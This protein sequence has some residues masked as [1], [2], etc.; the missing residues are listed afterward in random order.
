A[1]SSYGLDGPWGAVTVSFGGFPSSYTTDQAQWQFLDLLPA[2]TWDSYI[3]DVRACSKTDDSRCGA[4]GLWDRRNSSQCANSGVYMQGSVYAQ[5]MS[6][7]GGISG[8][9]GATCYNSSTVIVEEMSVRYPDGTNSTAIEIGYL[10]LGAKSST[11]SFALSDKPDD[12]I[13]TYNL[14]GFFYDNEITSSNSFSL[15]Y[16]A[17][18]LGFKGSLI[19]G[20]YDKGRAIGSA[21]TFGM[22]PPLL[23]DIV[24]GV[25]DGGSPF[26][27]TSKSGLLFDET[28]KSAQV[29]AFPDPITPYINL[30]RQTC[31]AIADLLPVSFD[32][33][34]GFYLWDVN[35][36]SFTTIISSPA[37]LGFVFPPAPGST[38]DVTIKVPLFLLNLTLD[39]QLVGGSDSVPYFPC[40]PFSMVGDATDSAWPTQGTYYLGRAFLQA[41]YYGRN[42][43]AGVSWLAQTPGPGSGDGLG[44]L[45][46]D[47]I[48]SDTSI[49]TFDDNGQLN[50]S[51]AGHWTPI[52]KTTTPTPVNTHSSTPTMT[53]SNNNTGL[54]TG[55]QAGIGV[56]VG[57][58]VLLALGLLF[59]FR[60]R[61]NAR[62][63]LLSGDA[64]VHDTPAW[65]ADDSN[66]RQKEKRQYV[67]EV[68]ASD[69]PHNETSKDYHE[70][71]NNIPELSSHEAPQELAGSSDRTT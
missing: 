34:S 54:S 13:N 37:Y 62:K 7:G 23:K 63:H 31:D 11:Q 53:A 44:Y 42:W 15:H 69:R 70:L 43:G 50:A 39:S 22:R 36:P 51:W 48:D 29:P 35:D 49:E 20:G 27:F 66:L 57:V 2:G 19:F 32:A 71:P 46:L 45:P 56:G 14:P 4:G 24:I 8:L 61:H 28:G 64:R 38:D 47:L 40:M 10:A 21:T 33:R 55:A 17:A 3:L 12:V 58:S 30:S 41:A 68:V 67:P 52:D 59:I 5:T 9:P 25:E 1:E 26:N 65:A 60:R 6:V 16:G 18:V